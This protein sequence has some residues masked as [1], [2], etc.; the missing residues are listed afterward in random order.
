M[1]LGIVEMPWADRGPLWHEPFRDSWQQPTRE[2]ATGGA[3]GVVLGHR[4]ASP[5][6]IACRPRKK[7]K[8]GS[9]QPHPTASEKPHLSQ[10]TREMGYTANSSGDLKERGS[11]PALR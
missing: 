3:V 10:R 1:S 4:R 5:P 7:R 2:T 6:Q 9:P 11:L 8:D